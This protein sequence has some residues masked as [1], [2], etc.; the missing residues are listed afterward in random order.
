MTDE[1]S[2]TSADEGGASYMDEEYADGRLDSGA[3]AILVDSDLDFINMSGLTTPVSVDLGVSDPMDYTEE[4]LRPDALVSFFEEGVGDVDSD[5]DPGTITVRDEV[6]VDD[7]AVEPSSTSAA[8]SDLEDLISGIT[9]VPVEEEAS[10]DDT[11]ADSIESQT[12]AEI[13][14]LLTSLESELQE[15][16]ETF[17]EAADEVSVE[18]APVR[19]PKPVESGVTEI[20]TP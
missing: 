20:E 1:E 12:S 11:D 15:K 9:E 2:Q 3:G 7:Q 16:P 6:I 10:S 5:M 4:N 14:S 8:V 19:S 18:A 13:E 17:V